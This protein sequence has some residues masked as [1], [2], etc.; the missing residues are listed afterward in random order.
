MLLRVPQ[1]VFGR[2]VVVKLAPGFRALISRS[3]SHTCTYRMKVKN[4]NNYWRMTSPAPPFPASCRGEPEGGP[5]GWRPSWHWWTLW[6][7]LQPWMFSH[8]WQLTVAA[9]FHLESAENRVSTLNMMLQILCKWWWKHSAQNQ[10]QH[11]GSGDVYNQLQANFL[12]VRTIQRD[13]CTSVFSPSTSCQLCP[14]TPIEGELHSYRQLHQ[15]L[16]L[17]SQCT[18]V[19]GKTETS[20]RDLS[21]SHKDHLELLQPCLT[22]LTQ[23][24][25][26]CTALVSKRSFPVGIRASISSQCVVVWSKVYPRVGSTPTLCVV[27]PDWRYLTLPPTQHSHLLAKP[28]PPS[29][30]KS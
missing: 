15:I 2:S 27:P 8:F 24:K 18:T 17:P 30:S 26:N 6:K 16:P 29:Y 20:Q 10:L 25:I 5:R 13:K 21:P 23:R 14:I 28:P 12:I 11:S 19:R 1:V 9:L 3:T 4:N 22:S 7:Y